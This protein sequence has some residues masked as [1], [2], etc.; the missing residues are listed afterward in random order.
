MKSATIKI[1]EFGTHYECAVFTLFFHWEIC[2]FRENYLAISIS[3]YQGR[4]HRVARGRAAA[5]TFLSGVII[6]AVSA[7]LGAIS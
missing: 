3:V 4:C 6:S 5:G 1:E 2:E 7:A